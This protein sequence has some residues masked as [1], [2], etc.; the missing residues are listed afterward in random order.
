M[1]KETMIHTDG[2]VQIAIPLRVWD[3]PSDDPDDIH[4][5]CHCG[6][7]VAPVP[8]AWLDAAG[9][10]IGHWASQCPGCGSEAS[11]WVVSDLLDPDD[12]DAQAA[13]LAALDA[14]RSEIHM[15]ECDEI[16]ARL[17]ADI[18]EARATLDADPDADVVTGSMTEP[19]IEIDS[20][21]ILNAWA[22]APN[23]DGY[24]IVTEERTNQP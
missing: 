11:A 24:I 18:A 13:A 10:V 23:L 22:P 7:F 2:H 12:P 1:K 6:A 19:G 14:E 8:W 15:A 4:G 21:G 9:N 16:T 5:V 17:F 20:D 3:D